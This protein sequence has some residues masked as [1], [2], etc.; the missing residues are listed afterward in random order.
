MDDLLWWQEGVIY[1][2]YPRSF[3]D[4]NQ[5]GL[6]DLRGITAHLDYLAG[7]GDLEL[8]PCEACLLK[9]A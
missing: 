3:A 8:G 9:G 6:G 7:L 5:D 4:D 1:Q 2:V